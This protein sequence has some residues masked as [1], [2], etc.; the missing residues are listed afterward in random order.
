MNPLADLSNWIVVGATV[1]VVSLCVGLHYEVLSGCSRF[2]AYRRHEPAG[3]HQRRRR[4]VSLILIILA[5]HV[6]EMW[7]FALGY[8]FLDRYGGLGTFDGVAVIGILDYAYYSATVYTTIGFGDITPTGP[9]RFM[10][11]MEGLTGLVMI[12]WSAS[13]TFI[14]MERYWQSD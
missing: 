7:L 14:G 11:G 6:V 4:I 9:I 3:H 5:T 8:F 10:T 12:T 13:F 1:I 2:L